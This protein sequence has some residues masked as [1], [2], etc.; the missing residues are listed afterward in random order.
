[1]AN[2]LHF[3]FKEVVIMVPWF[4]KTKII[5]LSL[6]LNLGVVAMAFGAPKVSRI[7]LDNEVATIYETE[8]IP[9]YVYHWTFPRF[10]QRIADKSPDA[11]SWPDFTEIKNSIFA[12]NWPQFVTA[13]NSFTDRGLFTWVNSVTGAFGFAGPSESYGQSLIRFELNDL[14]IRGL[15]IVN[16]KFALSPLMEGIDLPRINVSDYNLIYFENPRFKEWILRDPKTIKNLTA[17]PEVLRPELS[18]QLKNLK[19]S[20]YQFPEDQ[21]HGNRFKEAWTDRVK[22]SSE[23]PNPR[24]YM[25]NLV[26][27]LL[28]YGRSIIPHFFLRD[29]QGQFLSLPDTDEKSIVEKAQKQ[30][31]YNEVLADLK[32]KLSENGHS[33]YF[34]NP[35]FILGWKICDRLRVEI[36]SE[37]PNLIIF[38]EN[39]WD[40]RE[41]KIS[42]ELFK[43]TEEIGTMFQ[44]VNNG[45]SDRFNDDHFD[46]LYEKLISMNSTPEEITK[47]YFKKYDKSDAAIE[48]VRH[49]YNLRVQFTKSSKRSFSYA[50]SSCE[51]LLN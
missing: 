42:Y 27:S 47:E 5:Y 51:N 18:R 26:E 49:I 19:D 32:A 20:N 2:F 28:L 1:M 25:V 39:D 4:F 35:D 3:I 33:S 45:V 41:Y 46:D 38:Q 50:S 29:V 8:E 44:R 30:R 17:D 40:A 16:R 13:N 21:I 7:L 48:I 9:R 34:E 11:Q 14:K 24:V 37:N 22:K 15:V 36:L 12:R 43:A 31:A 23:I 10:L 6:F